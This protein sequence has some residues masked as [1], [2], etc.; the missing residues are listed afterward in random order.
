MLAWRRTS[1][2]L[3]EERHLRDVVEQ[4]LRESWSR[5]FGYAVSLCGDRETAR[6]LIQSSAVKALDTNAPPR[7]PA[8]ARAW[9]F[10]VMRNDW[11]DRGRR[12]TVRAA[13]REPVEP[14][15]GPWAYEDARIA[16]ITVRQGLDRL[17]PYQREI[18]ELVDLAG[19]RYA[20][21]AEILEVPV[22]TVMS[23]LS[24]ARLALLEAIEGGKVT[25]LE[26]SRGT[27]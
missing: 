18:I 6:D 23:R 25:P 2:S 5:L 8:A 3:W 27:R 17:E 12:A 16:A 7:E 20:E 13:D 19:F 4:C 1:D 10:R 22:G 26:R 14:T 24:R 11:I 21:A 9:L 15:E